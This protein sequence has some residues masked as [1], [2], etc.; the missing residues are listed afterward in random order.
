MISAT[1]FSTCVPEYDVPAVDEAV[2]TSW[3]RELPW[4]APFPSTALLQSTKDVATKR[5]SHILQKLIWL[6]LTS[7]L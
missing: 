5:V 3:K 4:K 7:I 2:D 6:V 1:S